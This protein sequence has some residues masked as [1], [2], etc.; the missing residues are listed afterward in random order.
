MAEMVKQDWYPIEEGRTVGTT[1][2]ERGVILQD[3]EYV[4]GAGGNPA[5]PNMI[6]LMSLIF[7]T[8]PSVCP[9]ISYINTPVVRNAVHT[10]WS[11][12]E[13]YDATGR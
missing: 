11:G 4:Q 9:F 13:N 10:A 12:K 2:S 5:L 7:V 1:G 8:W 6:R 3:E